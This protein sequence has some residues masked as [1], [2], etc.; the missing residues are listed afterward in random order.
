MFVD[1]NSSILSAS[2][3]QSNWKSRESP[4]W[5]LK[6]V[7]F[8]KLASHWPAIPDRMENLIFPFSLCPDDHQF[9]SISQSPIST[10]KLYFR[11]YVQDI[12]IQIP[13]YT[14][15][16][17]CFPMFDFFKSAIETHKEHMLW[18]IY[19]TQKS[20]CSFPP[21]EKL[22]PT[23]LVSSCFHHVSSP[24]FHGF[25]IP[26]PQLS[27]LPRHL[28]LDQRLFPPSGALLQ[29]SWGPTKGWDVGRWDW[30]MM[31]LPVKY[32]KNEYVRQKK[33]YC[34]DIE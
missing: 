33:W 9:G 4:V 25:H 12:P 34:I 7:H 28:K 14:P 30:K 19:P 6:S 1:L 3:F 17:D 18:V 10:P 22:S 8:W 5:C 21:K 13:H 32:Q 24:M 16:F 31:K 23:F 27:R 15:M 26:H 29:G 11:L 20:Y 2:P